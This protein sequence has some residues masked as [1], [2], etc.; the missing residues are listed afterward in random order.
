MCCATSVRMPLCGSS[1]MTTSMLA[2]A[3]TERQCDVSYDYSLNVFVCLSLPR[4][5]VR[6]DALWVKER[7]GYDVPA[8]GATM[9]SNTISLFAASMPSMFWPR[10]E[11]SS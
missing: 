5:L 1:S 4:S 8:A 7:Q 9:S 2:A 10:P 6:R 11:V 3:M